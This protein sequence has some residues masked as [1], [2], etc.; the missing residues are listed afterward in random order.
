[1]NTNQLDIIVI[2]A[3][4]AGV[5]AARVAAALGRS[6]AI[7]E[8]DKVGG[9]CVNVGCI[10]KK[11]YAYAG[12]FRHDLAV[13]QGYGW[14]TTASFSWDRLRENKTNEITRLNGI[15]NN[16]LKDVTLL[17]GLATC[18]DAH[19]ISVAGNQYSAKY[20][21]IATGGTPF[22]PQ[23]PGN[24]LVETSD[25]IFDIGAL[26]KKIIVVGGGYIAA[27]FA[28]I[29]NG[30]GC[31]TTL[32]YR[33][34]QIFRGFDSQIARFT[35]QQMIE[36]GIDIRL[37]SVVAAIK[38]NDASLQVVVADKTINADIVLHATGRSANTAKL[39]LENAGVLLNDNG[40]I[41][42]DEHYR[43]NQSHI[44]AIGDIVSHLQLTP[45]AIKQAMHVISH[46][47]NQTTH[48]LD[49]ATIPTAVFCTPN[50]G[51]VG[52]GEEDAIKRY[53]SAD[54]EIFFSNFRALKI[55]MS[56][57]TD[58]TMTKL[59]VQKSTQ[60]ILG[61]HMAGDH[62]GEVIQGFAVAVQMGCTKQQLDATV[63]IH[64]TTAE[65]FVTM[66]N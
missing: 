17:H 51:T 11:F 38:Q 31:E 56:A 44:Y 35:Q 21:I 65:E 40:S 14:D 18:V 53:G 57:A 5:R 9:T 6:V 28:S 61:I 13:M 4:S 54:I 10:P 58:K 32:L 50:I 27:E 45:V 59:V 25:T 22:V 23:F 63:G 8:A 15:Y 34:K 42:V 33:G 52:L 24:G 55:T 2:G 1:M 20:I 43:T 12:A 26:P 62:A 16:M 7:V 46:I 30:L 36:H 19:T 41:P 66:R 39:A 60:K 64:P 49:Y 29:F 37:H 3:G 47:T 48:P